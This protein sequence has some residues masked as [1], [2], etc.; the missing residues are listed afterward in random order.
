MALENGFKCLHTGIRKAVSST[1][2]DN[3]FRKGQEQYMFI[4]IGVL[5]CADQQKLYSNMAARIGQG[6]RTGAIRRK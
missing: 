4:R 1:D 2:T 6:F 5:S 3:I